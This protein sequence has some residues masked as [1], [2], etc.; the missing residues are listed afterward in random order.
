MIAAV[1]HARQAA[2][3]NQLLTTVSRPLIVKGHGLR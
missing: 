2:S 1:A 3:A